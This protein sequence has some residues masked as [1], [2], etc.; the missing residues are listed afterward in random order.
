MMA[1]IQLHAN[2]ASFKVS[3]RSLELLALFAAEACEARSIIAQTSED[4]DLMKDVQTVHDFAE[5][6]YHGLTGKN[7]PTTLVGPTNRGGK[8]V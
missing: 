6:L 4:P 8:E 3:P 5:V 1:A 2:E 7:L